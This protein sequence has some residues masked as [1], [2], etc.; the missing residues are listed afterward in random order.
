M[1]SWFF[2][3]ILFAGWNLSASQAQNIYVFK[4]LGFDSLRSLSARKYIQQQFSK[5]SIRLKPGSLYKEEL[6]IYRS[7]FEEV[8][9]LITKRDLMMDE[10]LEQYLQE[11]VAP[12]LKANP[13]IPSAAFRIYFSHAEWPNAYST[14]EGTLVFNAALFTRLKNESQVVFVLCHEMAHLML[15]HSNR[16]IHDYVHTL[17]SDSVQAQLKALK[18]QEFDRNKQLDEL[19]LKLAFNSR[20]YS[21]AYEM[22]ADSMAVALLAA[23]SYRLSESLSCLAL[24]DAI[25]KD[26]WEIEPE[27]KARFHATMYPFKPRWIQKEAAFFGGVKETAVEKRLADSLKTHPDCLLRREKIRPVIEALHVT[28]RPLNLHADSL[29]K[30]WQQQFEFEIVEYLFTSKEISRCLFEALRLLKSYPG[31][32]Y[33]IA[34]IGACWNEIYQKQREHQLGKIAGLPSANP[35][36]QY[37]RLLEFIQRLTL[38]DIALLNYYFLERHQTQFAGNPEQEAIWKKAAEYYAQQNQ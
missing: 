21:R 28:E 2:L 5:D 29:F 15:D 32:S 3:F 38:R 8:Q 10:K 20:H 14:G 36:S 26:D 13:S 6:K 7:R 37:N 34:K 27:L 22:Q 25:D 18:K 16:Q 9:S 11:L 31:N 33:L 19:E 12:V 24:L 4:P 23:T 35:E 17:Y 1:R 30:K